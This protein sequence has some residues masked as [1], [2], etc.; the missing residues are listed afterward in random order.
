MALSMAAAAWATGALTRVPRGTRP[1]MMMGAMFA[2]S[3]NFSIP[4]QE[5]AL[6]P[7]AATLQAFSMITFN[8]IQFTLGVG[9]AA[10][11]SP[12]LTDWRRTV[13]RMA[14]FPPLYALAAGVL[15]VELRD[16]MGGA[17]EGLVRA[18]EPFWYV[19][20]RM[21]GAFFAIALVTLGAQLALV[22]RG[23]R[24]AYPVTRT[25]ALRLLAGPAVGLA[26]IYVF[27][28]AGVEFGGILAPMLL[29]STAAPTAVNMMLVCLEFENHPDFAA[30]IVFYTTLASPV[31]VTL[32]VLV[33]KLGFL[34]GM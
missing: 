21:K 18:L 32:T 3:G 31:T 23:G 2:N 25:V 20:E 33:A 5:L 27:A 7:V 9:L 17:P 6:G 28:A 26:W 1:A 13:R 34:P 30:R 12:R 11:G 24:R 14:T 29:I 22:P 16:W 8:V 4:L 19:V 10:A 15:T